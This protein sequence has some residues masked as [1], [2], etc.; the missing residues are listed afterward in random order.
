MVNEPD[1][2][3]FLTA[4]KNEIKQRVHSEREVDKEPHQT[5]EGVFPGID[6][7]VRWEAYTEGMEAT[8]VFL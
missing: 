7:T 2:H 6:V 1:F 5:A 3:G 4:R 8:D